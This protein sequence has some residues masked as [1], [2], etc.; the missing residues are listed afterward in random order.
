MEFMKLEDLL[1]GDKI[2]FSKGMWA[3]MGLTD[4]HI[5]LY[6]DI[7]EIVKIMDVGNFWFR[8]FFNINNDNYSIVLKEKHNDN[9]I[10]IIELKED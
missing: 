6:S 2:K 7:V 3:L 4:Y 10:E 8:I 9:N 5:K 1:P